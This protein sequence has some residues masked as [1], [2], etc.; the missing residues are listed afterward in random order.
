MLDIHVSSPRNLITKTD[1]FFTLGRWPALR[2]LALT[3][4]NCVP[5]TYP[6]I[7]SFLFAHTNLEIL[8]LDIGNAATHLT[9]LD[10]T[11]PRIR[12]LRCTKEFA[13][14]LMICPTSDGSAR[15]LEVLRGVTLS[16]KASET[17]FYEQL[18]RHKIKRLEA[19]GF[20]EFED[21][22]RLV[23]YIPH[24]T[25]LDVGKKLN[26]ATTLA[27]FMNTTNVVDWANLLTTLPE[28]TTF[29]G[30]RFFYEAPLS[31]NGISGESNSSVAASASYRS[32]IKKNDEVASVL[33]W[34]CPKL[35]RV[36]CWGNGEDE[37]GWKRVIILSKD[38]EKFKW[39]VKRVKA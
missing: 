2:S 9:L 11:L 10:N 8:D 22:K 30:V 17:P 28:L 14:K 39:D 16:G 34:K 35:R 15:P 31:G 5:N 26:S 13:R 4:L 32:K 3:K 38:G 36:D 20:T 33:Y 23:E 1:D 25:W 12:E 7:S 24:V 27:P 21:V 19:S 18:R 29:H 6:L 37:A